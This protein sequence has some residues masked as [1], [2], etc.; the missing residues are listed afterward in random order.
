MA[1][2]SVTSALRRTL[3]QRHP[4]L[5]YAAAWTLLLT[6]AVVLTSLSPEMAFA[7]AVTPSSPFAGACRR[8]FVR[9]PVDGLPG[10]AVCVPG[11][12]LGP[13]KADFVVPP[14]FAAMVVAGSACLVSAVG[15][16][17]LTERDGTLDL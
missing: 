11:R 5:R 14:L 15:R 17:D 3:L 1:L 6:A 12:L 10:E 2:R 8:G 9:V 4:L 13:S 16:W 7:W